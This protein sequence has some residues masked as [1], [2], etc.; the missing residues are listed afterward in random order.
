[1]TEAGASCSPGKQKARHG[2]ATETQAQPETSL[3]LAGYRAR[4][5]GD[6]VGAG[7]SRSHAKCRRADDFLAQ[8]Q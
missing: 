4:A 5:R 8:I 7:G 2:A 3:T 6:K 1:M